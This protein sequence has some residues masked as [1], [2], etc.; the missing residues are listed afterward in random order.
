[1]IRKIHIIGG[2]GS[3]KSYIAKK[4][5]ELTKIKNYDLDDLFWDNNVNYYGKKNSREI[6]DAKLKNILENDSWIIEGV[7]SGW[8]QTSF[9]EA[10]KIFV[11]KPNIY[12]QHIRVIIRFIKRKLGLIPSKKSE[13]LKE[14]IELIKWN[15]GYNK[16][17][18]EADFIKRFKSKIVV[19][20][21]NKNLFKYLED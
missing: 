18:F 16:S 1:M 4:V 2:S 6:R 7:Y 14:L 19:L 10:D 15:S 11:L 12:L 3:G 17:L 9:Y 20:K 13:T 5:S 8:P 21:N